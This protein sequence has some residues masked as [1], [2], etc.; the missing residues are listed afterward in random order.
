MPEAA[1]SLTGSRRLRAAVRALRSAG[2]LRMTS[3]S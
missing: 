1:T 2:Y 3:G